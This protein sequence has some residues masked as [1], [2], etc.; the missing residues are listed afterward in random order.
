ML[1]KSILTMNDLTIDDV[2]LILNDALL[3]S[4]SF[5]DWQL[6]RKRLIANLFFESSTRTHYSFNSAELQLG[7]NIVDFN[8]ERSSLNKGESLYDTVKTFKS[9]GY[10]AVVIRH[11]QDEYFKELENIDIHIIN[12]GDGKGNHPSQSLLDLYTVYD[13]FNKF[14]DI[15]LLIV[16]DIRHSR[17]AHSN[18]YIFEK[19][20][21]N[22]KLSGP[23]ELIEDENRFIDLD[24]GVKW[25][26][27]VMLLRI[28]FERHKDQIGINRDEYL[29]KYGLTKDRYKMMKE[30]AIIM[31]PAPVNRGLEIDTDLVEAPKS[32]IF[33][34]MENG[35]LVRKAMLKY[36]F[37]EKF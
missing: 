12:A 6:S 23:E 21:A 32:R 14:E 20:G 26:D 15:N 3:F 27:V 4:N 36:I 8:A 17:V 18:M 34:Q 25:A 9:L 19:L 28:Q 11:E 35:V 7:A 22:V 1:K 29:E 31:H 13:E 5:K 2:N 16:G 37:D 33:K 10:D 24:E 30:N